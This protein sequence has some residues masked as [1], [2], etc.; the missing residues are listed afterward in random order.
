M[1]GITLSLTFIVGIHLLIEDIFIVIAIYVI[2][3]MVEYQFE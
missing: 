1:R 3:V 2:Q